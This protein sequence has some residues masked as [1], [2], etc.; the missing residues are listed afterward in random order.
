MAESSQQATTS[1]LYDPRV[2]GYAYQALLVVALVALV[3]SASHN[4]Y[5]N[6]QARG[7]PVG[8]GFWDETAGFEINQK[9]IDY[10]SVS[11]YGRAFWVGLVNTALVG[12]LSILLATP[13][14]FIIGVARLSPNWMLA[15]IALVYVEVMRNTP[16][17]LQLLFWYNAVLKA[18]PGPRQSLSV[19]G[20]VFLNNRGL[21]APRPE[22]ASGAGWIAVALIVGIASALAY[23]FWA[24]RRQALTGEQ[25]PV[26]AVA[27]LLC[28]GLPCAAYFAAGQPI[29]LDLAHQAGFNLTGGVQILPEL[30][31][32]LFGLATYTAG[33]IAEI[34]RSGVM[35]VSSGQS[36]AAN[37]LGLRPGLTMKLVVIPQAM[38]LITPPLTSQYLSVIKNS[39]LAVFIGYPDLVNVFAGIV[40]NQTHAALQVMAI[41]MGV[42]LAISLAVALAL[43][44]YNAR[45]ALK[46]R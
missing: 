1:L 45:Q 37:A 3:W 30:A 31:A 25:A 24:R 44:F 23:R 11:T 46:E 16:L 7:I 19:F 5:V 2:R 22:F 8:F 35:A 13:L 17:L 20:L 38:R 41:T 27:A 14:G 42:Y 33:F 15:K 21:Y 43:N 36:E 40:L 12:I 4:V 29:G 28:L 6:M 34:V 10:S 32:L 39:S 26:G 18:L 9:L